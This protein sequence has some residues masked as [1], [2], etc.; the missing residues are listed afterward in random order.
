ME[1]KRLQIVTDVIIHAFPGKVKTFREKATIPPGYDEK[2]FTYDIWWILTRSSG[3]T[4]T[5]GG[6]MFFSPELFCH[7]TGPADRAEVSHRS[8]TCG[9]PSLSICSGQVNC[10]GIKVLYQEHKT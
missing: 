3:P 7:L 2:I 9:H 6:F 1:T 8:K 4:P 5:T 10:P